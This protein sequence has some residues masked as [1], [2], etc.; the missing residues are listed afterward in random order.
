MTED[1]R[2]A[3]QPWRPTSPVRPPV[4]VKRVDPEIAADHVQ[5]V[6]EVAAGVFDLKPTTFGLL[7]AG[8]ARLVTTGQCDRGVSFEAWCKASQVNGSRLRS[9][10]TPDWIDANVLTSRLLPAIYE[11]PV[12]ADIIFGQS[13]PVRES[14]SYP[15][16]VGPGGRRY[17][18][19]LFCG[20]LTAD[21][22]TASRVAGNVIG[23][24]WQRSA[25]IDKSQEI[26]DVEKDLG[27]ALA[28]SMAEL[29]LQV[30]E[31]DEKLRQRLS[32]H[33][34]ILPQHGFENA[35]TIMRAAFP[36]LLMVPLLQFG[37]PIAADR[38]IGTRYIPGRDEELLRGLLLH[39]RPALLFAGASTDPDRI[40]RIWRDAEVFE[41]PF[42]KASELGI[43]SPPTDAFFAVSRDQHHLLRLRFVEGRDG[44]PVQR[45]SLWRG[46]NLTDS[47][48]RL[49]M[50]L[51]D[52]AEREAWWTRCRDA[53][54]TRTGLG[55]IRA[56]K[57]SVRAAMVH[58][59]VAGSNAAVDVQRQALYAELRARF[60][61]DRL[62]PPDH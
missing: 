39:Q 11:I 27:Y 22:F 31:R 4:D 7:A 57:T 36:K 38:S 61:R 58:Q 24:R 60:H 53:V 56:S 45:L 15:I 47:L 16:D 12:L 14:T 50:S 48:L 54:A 3:G 43:P 35:T 26:L 13:P 42:E 18:R 10:F 40:R 28:T 62:Q 41:G 25:N 44:E 17:L 55:L 20:Q 34:R 32:Q 9:Q 2:R 33:L 30:V 52:H 37:A 59:L 8:A 1:T 6:A 46:V 19:L 21:R 51:I 23:T 5:K 49:A 29:I